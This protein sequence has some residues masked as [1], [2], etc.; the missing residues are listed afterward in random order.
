MGWFRSDSKWCSFGQEYCLRLYY[1][2][3]KFFFFSLFVLAVVS[4]ILGA[5]RLNLQIELVQTKEAT[6]E[7]ADL[8]LP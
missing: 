1:G 5:D 3:G 8:T 6:L 7:R 4:S 2:R